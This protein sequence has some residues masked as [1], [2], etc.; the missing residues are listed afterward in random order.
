MPQLA[1]E[2]DLLVSY[3]LEGSHTTEHELFGHLHGHDATTVIVPS[4]KH[5]N[6]PSARRHAVVLIAQ[7][8]ERW[9]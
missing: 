1:A 4:E 8:R 6:V 2:L 3:A 5:I 7:T 9:F